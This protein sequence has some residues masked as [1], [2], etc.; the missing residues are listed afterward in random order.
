MRANERYNSIALIGFIGMLIF[1]IF[2]L[3][4][5]FNILLGYPIE[6]I[7]ELPKEI[8][9]LINIF[10][11]I[12]VTVIILGVLVSIIQFN[13]GFNSL[14]WGKL[15]LIPF[16]LNIIAIVAI[17]K[18]QSVTNSYYTDTFNFFISYMGLIIFFNCIAFFGGLLGIIYEKH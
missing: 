16:S 5:N 13:N 12:I 1:S 18:V 10:I 14:R 6:P 7:Y 17:L 4:I 2:Y 8:L 3:I 9:S 15:I 11:L